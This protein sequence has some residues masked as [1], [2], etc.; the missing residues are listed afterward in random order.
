MRVI[1]ADSYK[2][3]SKIAADNIQNVINEKNDAIL[4]LATGSTPIGTYEELIRRFKNG[5]IDFSQVKTINLD[6][7]VGLN[8]EHN[9]SYRYF[10]N[11]KLFNYIN[12]NIKNTYIPNGSAENI[13]D[14]VENYDK[15]I[16]ELGGIDI[17]IL[18]IGNNGHIAFN[19]PSKALN[20]GTHVAK[21]SQNTIK[22]NSRFFES[23]EDVPKTAITLGIGQILKAKKVILLANGKNKAEAIKKIL[24]GKITTYNPATML[25]LHSDVTLIID[26]EISDAI[27]KGNLS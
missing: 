23:L 4:G 26:K 14:E 22:A 1:V 13:E 5:K 7:Y 11:N 17:Q 27:I 8:K 12:I 19:E 6:E 9:Q 3:M 15:L 10:M 20:V 25:Q 18:G 2:A 16:E 21:L 24:S